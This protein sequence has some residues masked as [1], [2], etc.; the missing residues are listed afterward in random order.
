ML[1]WNE[2]AD[3]AAERRTSETRPARSASL[4]PF[5][6]KPIA[7]DLAWGFVEQHWEEIN[8]RFPSNWALGAIRPAIP[9]KS[10]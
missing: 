3:S 9:N 6:E 8:Q 4:P 7:P 2:T 10:L 1:S 5:P